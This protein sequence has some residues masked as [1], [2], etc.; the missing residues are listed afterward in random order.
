MP[1][2]SWSVVVARRRRRRRRRDRAAW[3][4]AFTVV[5]LRGHRRDACGSK[6]IVTR[7]SCANLIDAG[8]VV[9]VG[10]FCPNDVQ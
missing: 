4:M 6:A 9:I 3:T 5:L 2:S 7:M 10:F 8:F 1:D